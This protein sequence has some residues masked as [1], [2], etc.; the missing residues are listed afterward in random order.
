MFPGSQRQL[1][2]INPFASNSAFIYP[3]KKS[4]NLMLKSD[5]FRGQRKGALGTNGLVELFYRSPS[6]DSNAKVYTN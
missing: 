6:L 4:E 5:V 1:W 2:C 3:L